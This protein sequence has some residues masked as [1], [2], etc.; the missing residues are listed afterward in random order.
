MR[1]LRL[2]YPTSTSPPLGWGKEAMTLAISRTDPN[3]IYLGHL[4]LGG[5][6][7]RALSNVGLPAHL[8]SNL[9]EGEVWVGRLLRQSG[10]TMQAE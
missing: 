10:Q 1:P 7:I 9:L 2:L 4:C 3:W 8:S 5:K 6:V